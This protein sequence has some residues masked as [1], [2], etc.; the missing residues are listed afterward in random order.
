MRGVRSVFVAGNGV[1][2]AEAGVA[3][4]AV[5]GVFPAIDAM[6]PRPEVKRI[7]M[8]PNE[9]SVA[10]PQFLRKQ[11]LAPGVGNSD[12]VIQ[13]RKS[14]F[15]SVSRH[16]SGCGSSEIQITRPIPG[17]GICRSTAGSS[18]TEISA[19]WQPVHDKQESV[20]AMPPN[21]L[22]MAV[23]RRG[24]SRKSFMTRHLFSAQYSNRN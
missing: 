8:I 14:T 3:A 18:G 23:L 13:L 15:D 11:T 16:C 6:R 20:T 7:S 24:W 21:D 12:A 1:C 22:C 4:P 17:I 2:P 19:N 10:D 5:I 9:K